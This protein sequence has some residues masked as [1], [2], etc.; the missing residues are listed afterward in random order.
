[1][2]VTKSLAM[3]LL[4]VLAA[5][6]LMAQ[7][8]DN[9]STSNNPAAT[10]N[11][12]IDRMAQHEA[13]LVTAMNKFHPMVETYLQMV[14]F[15][16][17][18]GNVPTNDH[19]FLG[20]LDLGDGF[21]ERFYTSELE[22]TGWKASLLTPLTSVK[23]VNKFF[24][25]DFLPVGF[26][27]MLFPDGR[28]FNRNRYAFHFLRR[29]FLGEVRCLVFAV[30]P[31]NKDHGR[32][33]G[34]IWVEDKDY[35]LVRFSGVYTHPVRDTYFHM[36]SWRTNVQPGVWLP[37]AIYEEETALKA[38]LLKKTVRFKGQT[39]LWGY[40][41]KHAGR[42]EEFTDMQIESNDGVQDE[43][44]NSADFSPVTSLRAWERESE[45]N[46]LDKLE[47]AGL[48]APAGPVDKVLEQIVTNVEAGSNLEIEP[49][50]RC[51][52][53][54]TS[55]LESAT[56]GHTIVISRGLLDVVPDE[57]SLAMLLTLELGRIA[58]GEQ[59]DTKYS[60][61][62]R[63]QFKDESTYHKFAFERSPEEEAVSDKK[64]LELF[65]KSIYKDK[66]SAAGLFLRQ[67]QERAEGMP[68]LIQARL[69]NGLVENG[70]V[71][72]MA[73]LMNAAPALQANK[74]EQVAALPLGARIK[75]NP[76]D[77]KVE[78]LKAKPVQ[79]LSAR[80]KMPFEVS[81]VIMN[82]SRNGGTFNGSASMAALGH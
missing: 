9:V 73:E 45:E 34:R 3:L 10:V 30:D 46:V 62:D 6:S 31:V 77:G 29:E 19:Y 69:G 65:R 25:L 39:R 80:E 58:R 17:E 20:R 38:S 50:V 4:L 37:T 78:L 64:A 51:R 12:A 70:S 5:G 23:M 40:D 79:L 81:P 61:G 7:N 66:A 22:K 26:S 36:D 43:N 57:A 67:L 74:V 54:L 28:G 18:Q 21:H 60:F 49:E 1:M 14:R 53:L 13:A 16:E 33:V 24:T 44:A 35:N 56:I 63:L 42:Q 48:L 11:Q 47:T 72:R 82:L 59:I 2:R 8:T 75:V 76:W 32:F 27:S 68:N 55:P 41:L 52:I 71:N 15:D